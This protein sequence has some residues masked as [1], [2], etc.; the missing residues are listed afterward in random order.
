MKLMRHIYDLVCKLAL[1]AMVGCLAVSCFNDDYACPDETGD[2]KADEDVWIALNVNSLTPTGGRNAATRA[3]E[4]EDPLGH[5]A[6]AARPEENYIDP[7]DLTLVLFDANGHAMRTLTGNNFTLATL[8]GS[9]NA[10]YRLVA[11]VNRGWLD[12]AKGSMSILAVANTNGI[13]RADLG[14]AA[15]YENITFMSTLPQL[16]SELRTFRYDGQ[17]T[18]TGYDDAWQPDIQAGRHIPMSGYTKG[19]ALDAAALDGATTPATALNLGQIPMQRAMAKIRILDG[20][21]LQLDLTNHT[22]IIK[23]AM[24]NGYNQ[25]ATVPDVSQSGVESWQNGTATVENATGPLTAGAWFDEKI[26]YPSFVAP[27]VT[28]TDKDGVEQTFTTYE[29]YCP[30]IHIKSQQSADDQFV[31]YLDITV[32]NA[33]GIKE[34][35]LMMRDLV[36]GEDIVRNHIY[37]Y[38]VTASEYDAQLQLNVLDWET[39]TTEWDYSENPGLTAPIGWKD[40]TYKSIDPSAARLY[41]SDEATAA[42]CSFTLD[43][44]RGATWRAVLVPTAGPQDAFG[45]MDETGNLVESIS[46]TIDGNPINL[47]IKPRYSSDIRENY[48]ARLQILVT[49]PDNRT[50]SVDVLGGRYGANTFFTIVQN[51]QI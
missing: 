12:F 32:R 1:P 20:V 42:A 30:E 10:N 35:T 43:T 14:T 29:I 17:L 36:D 3:G 24:R 50:M 16:T 40:G 13:N 47:S 23:V 5:P 31:P 8:E 15:G 18:A 34:Y 2:S 9:Q 33:E 26:T 4:P 44:P 48:S 49:T 41:V 28:A 21:R 38:Y 22:E 45:F 37:Q 11:K 27:S 25:G 51:Q 6:E 39:E 7:N 46:G 19:I